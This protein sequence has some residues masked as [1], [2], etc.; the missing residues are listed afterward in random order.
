M[1]NIKRILSAAGLLTTGLL[2]LQTSSAHATVVMAGVFVGSASTPALF[3]AASP[4]ICPGLCPGGS[5]AWTMTAAGVGIAADS[6]VFP[7]PA[8]APFFTLAAGGSLGA[9]VALGGAWCEWSS[10]LGTAHSSVSPFGSLPTHVHVSFGMQWT[11][12]AGSMLVVTAL[13]L[14]SGA[15]LVQLVPPNPVL[16][17]GS[18]LFGSATTFTVVGAGVFMA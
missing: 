17:G 2:G 9:G 15:A 8:Y 5:G 14:G 4:T 3:S 7:S 12:S 1:R 6:A 16:G 10:G 18:C 13:P 11:T